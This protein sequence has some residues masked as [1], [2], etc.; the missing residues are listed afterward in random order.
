MDVFAPKLSDEE[1]DR[2]ETRHYAHLFNKIVPRGSRVNTNGLGV[3]TKQAKRLSH[4][5]EEMRNG[6]ARAAVWML[7]ACIRTVKKASCLDEAIAALEDELDS[8]ASRP[9]TTEEG[10][11]I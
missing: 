5:V 3:S 9:D 1:R 11:Q 10:S 8:P 4:L 7:K 6:R 2:T